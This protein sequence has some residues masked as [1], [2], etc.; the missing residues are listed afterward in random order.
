MWIV[1]K[2]MSLSSAQLILKMFEHSLSKGRNLALR[3]KNLGLT[4][5]TLRRLNLSQLR[6]L[7]LGYTLIVIVI[8][9][10]LMLPVS[11]AHGQSQSF[12][13]ALFM[14]SSGISTTGLT[15]VKIGEY[16]SL[17]GQVI[18]LIDFQIGGIGYMALFIFL[19]YLLQID[20]SLKSHLVATESLS[21]ARIGRNYSFFSKVI[22][23]TM[24]F[25][26]TGGLILGTYWM[27][28]FSWAHALYLG[29][30]HSIS[31]FCTAGFCLFPES[32]IPYSNSLVVNAVIV[33]LSLAGG[34]GFFVLNEAI[35]ALRMKMIRKRNRKLSVHT[36]LAILVTAVLI[37]ISSTIIFFSEQWSSSLSFF[38]KALYSSFQAISAS[39][40]DGFNTLNISAMSVPSLFIIILLMLTGASPGSTGGGIKTTTLGSIFLYIK[41]QLTGQRDTNFFKQ[42]IPEETIRKSFSIF[43]LFAGI[44]VLDLLLMATTENAP[45]LAILFESASALGNTGLSMGITSNLSWIG[46]LAL[47]MTMF[48]GRVGPLT[49]GMALVGR[50][51]EVRFSYADGEVYV[52]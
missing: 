45:F 8:S 36:R 10:L 39:T 2:K 20:F 28:D 40:T 24:V 13:D 7:V 44:M 48:I 33:I 49:I 21:G 29:V 19:G 25:E 41:A 9:L 37:S 47:S 38:K 14:A 51:K 46:K 23:F 1:D 18:L 26:L 32:L 50:S 17:F 3:F 30:F 42:R 52:G 4:K 34:I 6:I 43:F 31:A 15:V 22:F 16:Y 35:F 12:I 11:N 27:R 5:L